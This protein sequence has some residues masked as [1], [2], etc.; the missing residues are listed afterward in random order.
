MAMPAT[1]ALGNA[2]RQM[3]GETC[4]CIVCIYIHIIYLYIMYIYMYVYTYIYIYC[5]IYVSL[6]LCCFAHSQTKPF[7]D[8]HFNSA[9]L[10]QLWQLRVAIPARGDSLLLVECENREHPRDTVTS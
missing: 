10:W 7:A 4:I 8:S 2:V 6:S 9:A 3:A 1:Q 5:I